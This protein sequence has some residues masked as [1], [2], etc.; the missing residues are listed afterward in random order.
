[1][2]AKKRK[3]HKAI[4]EIVLERGALSL[5]ALADILDVSTQT[6]RRDVDKLCEDGSLK[7]RH[8]RVELMPKQS[9]TPFD[10]RVS[11]NLAEKRDIGEAAAN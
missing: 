2:S 9:N 8:G 10:L 11:T 1:M 4:K 5:G 3:R 7:R 6:I